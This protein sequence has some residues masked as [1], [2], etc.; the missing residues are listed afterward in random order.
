MERDDNWMID[1]TRSHL[2]KKREK[3]VNID[4]LSEMQ[5]RI[6][7]WRH[8]TFGPVKGVALERRIQDELDEL[9]M[10]L[11]EKDT[12][13]YE[14]YRIEKE[15]ADVIVT[16]MAWFHYTDRSLRSV[17]DKV[18]TMNEKRKWQRHGD[19]SGQHIKS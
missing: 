15:C 17:L 16:I 13:V 3:Q 19:G 10:E 8:D 18:Q 9:M 2:L 4:S 5:R 12:D 6:G 11:P 7:Q 14:E 1:Q